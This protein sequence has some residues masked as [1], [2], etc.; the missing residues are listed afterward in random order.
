VGGC[1]TAIRN[2]HDPFCGIAVTR[3]FSVTASAALR[4]AWSMT[5][6]A[7]RALLSTV[8]RSRWRLVPIVVAA[9]LML[10]CMASAQRGGP[11][12]STALSVR[13]DSEELL[14]TRNEVLVHFAVDTASRWGW[15]A[16]SDSLDR[17]RYFWSATI[18]GSEG[19][20]SFDL[21]V[22]AKDRRAS[23][24]PSLDSLVRAGTTS[25]CQPGMMV[26]CFPTS[27]VASVQDRRV[28]LHYG[29]SAEIARIFRL[30]PTSATFMTATPRGLRVP[31]LSAVPIR[32]LEPSLPPL[33]SAS[34]RD[35]LQAR[36]RYDASVN[37]IYRHLTGAYWLEEDDSTQVGIEETHCVEDVCAPYQG[38]RNV[39]RTWGRWSS[40]DTAVARLH[41][42][43]GRITNW[44]LSPDS[45]RVMT[46]VALKPGRATVRASGV[47]DPADLQPGYNPVDSI[48]TA[49]VLV[50]PPVGRLAISPR[51]KRMRLGE[52]QSFT[53][54][55]V[56]RAGRVIEGTPV[57]LRWG[58]RATDGETAKMRFLRTVAQETRFASKPVAVRFDKPGRYEI[59]AVLGVTGETA[60]SPARYADTV[61][62]D[63]LD[64]P[65]R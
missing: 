55:V 35:A 45:V 29:D 23:A 3:S 16:A 63:V 62:V 4:S 9:A 32:Y 64:R 10:P 7:H 34:R 33:D 14:V 60:D 51:P 8:V 26:H 24:F 47:H 1:E 13:A 36:R 48:V 31:A 15:P 37:T 40:S 2:A 59:V 22:K 58:N 53:V 42:T 43:T 49:E 21:V 56:D 27:L 28:V 25:L 12:S 6:L 52:P 20:R 30:R 41:P 38:P 54:R 61:N 11:S 46:L 57:Q 44:R 65:K 39:P 19:P 17:A 5:S 50:T 18:E